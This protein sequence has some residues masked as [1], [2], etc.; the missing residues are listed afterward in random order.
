MDWCLTML[1]RIADNEDLEPALQ[2]LMKDDAAERLLCEMVDQPDFD[3]ARKLMPYL[4]RKD[5]ERFRYGPKATR[6]RNPKKSGRKANKKVRA[7]VI[8]NE[9]LTMLWVAH[10]EGQMN[11][12][13]KPSR[14]DILERR[15]SLDTSER[16]TVENYISKLR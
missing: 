5:F 7:A 3:R 10:F 11:R 13:C 15:H 2:T 16:D 4:S 12:P 1:D 9:R 14:L 6:A 8:D